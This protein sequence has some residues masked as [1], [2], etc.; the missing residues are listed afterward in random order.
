MHFVL[1]PY[2]RFPVQSAVP[3]N[4][5]PFQ[6]QDTIWN[7]SCTGWRFSGDLPMRPGEPL[8]LTVT[9]IQLIGVT[10]LA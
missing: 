6:G 7:L 9:P 3:Y 10:E 5:G 1:R 2:R 8:S 4:A